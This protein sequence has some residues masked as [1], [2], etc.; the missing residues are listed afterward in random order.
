MLKE[1]A[2]YAM[3]MSRPFILVK[4]LVLA[5]AI[6]AGVLRPSMGSDKVDKST[7]EIESSTYFFVKDE[8]KS[9]IGHR[10]L[11]TERNK[12]FKRQ[13]ALFALRSDRV[14]FA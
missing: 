11:S 13:E 14:G 4:A 2:Q 12:I 3:P 1:A 9:E 6:L 7:E 5:L 10:H 8:V